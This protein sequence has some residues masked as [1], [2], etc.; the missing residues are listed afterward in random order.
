MTFLALEKV[1]QLILIYYKFENIIHS[2]FRCEDFLLNLDLVLFLLGL[3]A[4][5]AGKMFL[6]KFYS[7]GN[8]NLARILIGKLL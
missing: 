1:P 3:S 6:I 8:L 2:F 7:F 4:C 5:F